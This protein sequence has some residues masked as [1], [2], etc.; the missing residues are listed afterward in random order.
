MALQ[1][2]TEFQT[3]NESG[4][5]EFFKTL[6]GALD[7]Y[8]NDPTIWK[9]SYIHP[10]TNISHRWRCKCAKDDLWGAPS[11]E[12]LVQLLPLYK[13]AL[14]QDIFWVDQLLCPERLPLMSR[15][16]YAYI[17]DHFEMPDLI[18]SVLTD[19]DFRS[20]RV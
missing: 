6:K 12:K 11:E 3:R 19:K 20:L 4:T 8:D 5:L 18:R 16:D 15:E 14:P 7:A 17:L 9:I 2:K 13:D 1:F 10:I